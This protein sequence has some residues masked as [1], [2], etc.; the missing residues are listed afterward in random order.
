MAIERFIWTTHALVRLN[1]RHL[2]RTD[3][4]R[5]ILEGHG[6][7]KANE[8]EADWL[9]E[10]LTAHGVRFEAVYD[11]PVGEDET[12]ARIVSAWRVV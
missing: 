5:A 3:V 12:T 8:G 10:G 2:R 7:R 6:G 11:H 4:E 9:V 1:E